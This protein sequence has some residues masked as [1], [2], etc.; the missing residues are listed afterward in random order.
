MGRVCD[1]ELPPRGDYRAHRAVLQG[2]LL[3]DPVQLAPQIVSL[4][5][6]LLYGQVVLVHQR[7]EHL[8]NSYNPKLQIRHLLTC[9]TYFQQVPTD[10]VRNVIH[11]LHGELKGVFLERQCGRRLFAELHGQSGLPGGVPRHHPQSYNKTHTHMPL[12][13]LLSVTIDLLFYFWIAGP[14]GSQ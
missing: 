14:G 5:A 8:Q 9:A 1:A 2:A 11:V 7:L 12:S 6:Q 3:D 13:I 4:Q 10:H